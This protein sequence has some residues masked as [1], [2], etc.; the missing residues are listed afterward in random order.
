MENIEVVGSAAARRSKGKGRPASLPNH[1]AAFGI[2]YLDDML[3]GQTEHVVRENGDDKCGLPCSTVT[4]LIG[5]SE[6]Q[7]SPLGTAFLSRCFT[8]Y[9]KKYVRILKSLEG[10]STGKARNLG[11]ARRHNRS[12]LTPENYVR[13]ID[14]IKR[15]SNAAIAGRKEQSHANSRRAVGKTGRSEHG[16]VREL[17]D[18][19]E[20]N[21]RNRKELLARLGALSQPKKGTV[22]RAK[23]EM[24]LKHYVEKEFASPLGLT[25]NDKAS[26]TILKHYC[27]KEFAPLLRLCKQREIKR[28]DLRQAIKEYISLNALSRNTNQKARGVQT[29]VIAPAVIE[30][31]IRLG[32]PSFN[33]N[34][35]S[36]GVPVLLTTQDV[37][38]QKLA[39]DFLPWLLQDEPELRELDKSKKFGGCLAGLRIMM[40]EYIICR[41][42]EIHDLPSAVLIH[43]VRCAVKEA[44][45]ILHKGNPAKDVERRFQVSW[46]IRVVFDDFSILKTT[47]I[48]IRDEPLLVRFLAFYL[49]REGVTTLLIDTQSGRPDTI[50]ASQLESELRSLVDHRIYTWRFPFLSENRV[51]ISAIPPIS[52][53]APTV[54]RELR[55]VANSYPETTLVPLVVDPHFEFYSGIEQGKPQPISLEIR[56]FEESPAFAEYVKQENVRYCDLFTPLPKNVGGAGDRVIISVPTDEYDQFRDFCYLQR[57]TRLDHTLI[58]QVD[59]FWM[60][61]RRR[62]RRTSAFRPQWHYLN[63][64][65]DE[66]RKKTSERPQDDTNTIDGDDDLVRKAAMLKSGWA[67]DPAR[68]F[69][70]TRFDRSETDKKSTRKPT[71]RGK[72]AS[73]ADEFVWHGYNFYR[74]EDQN[75]ELKEA[76]DRVP[77]MW[78]FGFLLCRE[79]PWIENQKIEL[80]ILRLHN[81]KRWETDGFHRV[82][83]VWMS[84]P[85]AIKQRSTNKKATKQEDTKSQS[86]KRP[87][88]RVFLEACYHVARMQ[89]YARGTPI[90]AF[91]VPAALPQSLSCLILEIWASEIF[92]TKR[93]NDLGKRKK[94]AETFADRLGWRELKLPDEDLI[95]WLENYQVEL[96]KTWL[97][98]IEVLDMN[99]WSEAIK[100]GNLRA[101]SI[102]PSTV[103]ARH[104]YKTACSAT[105]NLSYDEP[106]VPVGLPGHFSMRGDWF[107]TVAGGSRSERLASLAIDILNSRRANRVRL[108][109]GL[110]LPTRRLVEEE[111]RLSGISHP[112]KMPLLKTRI[113]TAHRNEERDV[114]QASQQDSS[115]EERG[116]RLRHV[117]Y[118]ELISL[119][120]PLYAK[121][122]R[123]SYPSDVQLDFHWLWRSRLK[124]FHRHARIWQDWIC[125]MI[126]RWQYMRYVNRENWV[127]GFER[128]DE[129]ERGKTSE[130][131]LQFEDWCRSLAD[132][133][134][135][136][137]PANRPHVIN[138]LPA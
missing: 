106:I 4:A 5:N 134:K 52:P 133:L 51:A 125:Q 66:Q 122:E 80:S 45:H 94:S 73:R 92:E 77:F 53:H 138:T 102:N 95:D 36:D 84:L 21:N 90:P 40:E 43:I 136:A 137:T 91:D 12:I 46:G 99:E 31:A 33:S 37:H 48:D 98:L 60:V 42:L 19:L 65:L 74:N 13:Q 120:G 16:L 129:I 119:G 71:P 24:L 68:I 57:D 30:A 20:G 81:K 7:K 39:R 103:A 85:M 1:F 62:V 44:Q 23:I 75:E 112:A 82:Q 27:D 128:Y 87:S 117:L 121:E 79:D 61:R 14:I 101:R 127:N 69:E 126:L 83:D 96:F 97:L 28:G 35:E 34:G 50:T 86:K 54:T 114:K 130:A 55:V 41:R 59:E 89:T 115:N 3:G 113:L 10:T 47:Y 25:R 93:K 123:K 8:E 116:E 107:L 11:R 56:L 6:T 108:E 15:L 124:Y 88:W 38:A 2:H 64:T 118:H 70:E 67:A 17:G 63:T 26:M 135:E 109:S 131:Q 132:Q 110:G 22:H 9:A 111:Q 29:E 76:I 78:D 58:L 18:Y 72:K 104:W 100:N 32:P 49:G 105:A